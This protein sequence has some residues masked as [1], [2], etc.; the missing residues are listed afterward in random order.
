MARVYATRDDLVA[1]APA[2][3]TVPDE[4]EAGRL[5]ARASEAVEAATISAVYAVDAAGMPTDPGILAALRDATCAQAV[6]W[7]TTG[8]ELGQA[9]RWQSVSIGSISLSGGTSATGAGG[10]SLGGLA[11]SAERVLRLAGLLPGVIVH[12]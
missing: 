2:G 7:L 6:D 3:V 12:P 5:L 11:V 10:T 8:D 1:Y 9:G 4:P